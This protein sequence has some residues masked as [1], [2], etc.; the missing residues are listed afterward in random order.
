MTVAVKTL[1][2]LFTW[3]GNERYTMMMGTENDFFS[4]NQ[5]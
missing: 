1:E 5:S 3:C 2:N 4:L